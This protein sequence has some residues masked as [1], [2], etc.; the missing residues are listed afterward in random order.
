MLTFDKMN[1][2]LETSRDSDTN[3]KKQ[4]LDINYK[5]DTVQSLHNL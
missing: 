1:L 5:M 2:S 4:Q 3:Y